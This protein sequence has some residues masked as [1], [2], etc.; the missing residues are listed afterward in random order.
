M[1]HDEIGRE[2]IALV[3]QDPRCCPCEVPGVSEQG[4]VATTFLWLCKIDKMMFINTY[5][6]VV[7][8]VASKNQ[9]RESPRAIWPNTAPGTIEVV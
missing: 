2:R 6:T 9:K 8:I 5:V 7:L 4:R 1:T 3:S